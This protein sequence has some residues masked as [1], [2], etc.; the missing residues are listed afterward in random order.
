MKLNKERKIALA[1]IA[2]ALV[3]IGI[4]AAVT[5]ITAPEHVIGTPEDRP[6]PPPTPVLHLTSNNT[7][8]FYKNDTLTMTATLTPA[9]AGIPVTLWNKGVFV[10]TELTDSSGVVVFNRK[11]LNPFD[12]T[13]SAE[14]P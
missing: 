1:V 8:P 7:T 5:V 14:L 4:V 6:A 9:Q 12:Y 10:T 13:V 2:I 11:P 3:V